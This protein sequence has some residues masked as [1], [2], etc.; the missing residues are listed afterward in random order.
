M[1]QR[2][3]DWLVGLEG[4]CRLKAYYDSGGIPTIGVG[5]TYWPGTGGKRRVKTGE[6]LD[7]KAQG[8]QLFARTLAP[9]EA[10][11]DAVT[12]DSITQ[13]EYD[14]FVSLCYNIGQAAFKASSAVRLFNAGEPGSVVTDALS[15]WC[16]VDGRINE[17][18][19]ERRACEAD[20][21][22]LGR[23]RLQGEH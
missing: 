23:Y 13:H 21:Y 20:L 4:G 22:T 10:T 14:A 7:S 11:V 8:L 17:G 16:R 18:L 12:R 9:Y 19:V 1:S 6:C 15:R 2:G 3:R 5:M